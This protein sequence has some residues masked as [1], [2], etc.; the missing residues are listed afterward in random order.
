MLFAL[1]SR[2]SSCMCRTRRDGSADASSA[3]FAH[4]CFRV[5]MGMAGRVKGTSRKSQGLTHASATRVPT[6][7]TTVLAVTIR[8]FRAPPSTPCACRSS[9]SRSW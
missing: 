9:S 6:P 2:V 5:A 4:F 8:V 1:R 7:T 3:S